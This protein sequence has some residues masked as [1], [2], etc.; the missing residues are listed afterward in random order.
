MTQGTNISLTIKNSLSYT[1][2]AQLDKEFKEQYGV[3]DVQLGFKEWQ[4]VFDVIKEDNATGKKQYQGGDSDIRNGKHFQVDDEQKYQITENAWTKIV[5]I[6]KQKM[7]I[8]AQQANTTTTNPEQENKSVK[9][10]GNVNNEIKT[11]LNKS[12]IDFDNLDSSLK[13]DIIAKYN[14][15]KETTPDISAEKLE[16]RITNYAKGLQ[17]KQT[18]A[19][20]ALDYQND[21]T[22]SDT[23]YEIAGVKEAMESFDGKTEAS[24]NKAIEKQNAAFHQAAQ[25][26]IELCDNDGD[27]KISVKEFILQSEKDE[28]TRLGRALTAKEKKAVKE[29]AINRIALL[30][31]NKD[32]QLDSNEMAAFVWATAKVNDTETSKSANDITYNEWVT[33]EETMT[34]V[35]LPQ[36]EL[37]QD[38]IDQIAKF[39]QT[40]KNR[41]DG[42]K[43]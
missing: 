32:N 41:Y 30:D 25:E 39:R 12:N 21:K 6:A 13:S 26:R 40:L 9:S 3:E 33:A 18:E 2:D 42:L 36:S 1:I 29:E 37:T 38:D 20:F 5:N 8:T 34:L 27:G 23:K 14:A 15:I 43:K 28:E 16:Q 11:Y 7:G 4:S 17:Y 35:G 22:T 31:Q 24:Y 10:S 19:K